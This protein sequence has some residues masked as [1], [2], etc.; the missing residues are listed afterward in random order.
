MSYDL[1]ERTQKFGKDVVIFCN[2]LKLNPINRPIIDQLLR[3][4]TSV[5]ANYCEANGAASKKD[6]RNKI[7]ICKREAQETR[8][9]LSMISELLTE[10]VEANRLKQEAHEFSLIFGKIAASSK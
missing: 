9:W 4:G 6:F 8:Y 1:E 7:H 5:G 2:G 3:A 10:K